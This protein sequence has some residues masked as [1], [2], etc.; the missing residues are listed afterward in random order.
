M[1]FRTLTIQT[2]NEFIYDNKT[3]DVIASK[4][5]MS[6]WNHLVPNSKYN[7]NVCEETGAGNA[8]FFK[9]ELKLSK[10]ALKEIRYVKLENKNFKESIL[11]NEDETDFS[12]YGFGNN[13]KKAKTRSAQLALQ[14]VFAITFT[15]SGLI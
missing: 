12:F 13:K 5:I 8:K 14:F 9:A 1:S 10:N 11:V 4:N 2:N 6:I 7:F 15:H 3:R